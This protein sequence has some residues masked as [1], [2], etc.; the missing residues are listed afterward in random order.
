MATL[1]VLGTVVLRTKASHFLKDFSNIPNCFRGS[2][3]ILLSIVP[4]FKDV[5]ICLCNNKIG[6]EVALGHGRL[7]TKGQ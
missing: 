6:S 2:R 5:H 4:P 3:R 7:L 1:F